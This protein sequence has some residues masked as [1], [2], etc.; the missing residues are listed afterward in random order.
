MQNNVLNIERMRTKILL[1]FLRIIEIH[2]H[3]INTARHSDRVATISTLMGK[4]IGLPDREIAALWRSGLLHDIG[5]IGVV[6]D[7]LRN[8]KKLTDRQRDIVQYHP[9]WAYD[10]LNIL[11]LFKYEA[12]IIKQHHENFDGTGYPERLYGKEIHL[13]ARIIHVVD[14]Y[15]ALTTFR[16]YKKQWKPVDAL[17]LI[18]KDSGTVF[19]P[20]IVN[21]FLR[22]AESEKFSSVYMG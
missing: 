4:E 9:Q 7:V 3:S 1:S 14:V 12:F 16:S 19:D 17:R 6:H 21:M 8:N 2:E 5:K 10:I 18:Y 13:Y 11:D 20:D 22:I 15:D